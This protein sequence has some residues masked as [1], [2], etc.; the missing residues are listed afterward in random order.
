ML[1]KRSRVLNADSDFDERAPK[2]QATAAKVRRA[3]EVISNGKL[4]AN[5]NGAQPQK[6]RRAEKP[7]G[8][9][10]ERSLSAALNGRLAVKK[11]NPR[12]SPAPENYRRRAKPLPAPAVSRKKYV[13][14]PKK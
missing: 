3:P 14:N 7:A 5:V 8:T 4:S 2:K 9:A 13:A 12:A 6:R 10:M 1:A 11:D